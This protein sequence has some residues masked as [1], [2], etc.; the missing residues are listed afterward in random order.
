MSASYEDHVKLLGERR[1]YHIEKPEGDV[2]YARTK[3]ADVKEYTAQIFAR[4]EQ[5][6]GN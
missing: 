5:Y 3:G 6:Q 2:D 4:E 1:K